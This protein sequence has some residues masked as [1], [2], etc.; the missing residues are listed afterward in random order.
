M[1]STSNHPRIV[2]NEQEWRESFVRQRFSHVFDD[3]ALPAGL[4]YCMSGTAL[5]FDADA[6][7]GS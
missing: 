1:T 3:G 2:K 6:Q 7:A 4:R 5:K